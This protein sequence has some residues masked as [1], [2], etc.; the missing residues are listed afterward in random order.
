MKEIIQSP[1]QNLA[2][3]LRRLGVLELEYIKR[4][5]ET[6]YRGDWTTFRSLPR[7]ENLSNQEIC[8]EILKARRWFSKRTADAFGVSICASS[9]PKKS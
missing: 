3:N 2:M 8:L 5:T 9:I 4:V 7:V 1:V 6:G